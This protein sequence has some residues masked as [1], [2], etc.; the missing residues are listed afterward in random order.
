MREHLT[1][2]VAIGLVLRNNDT[3]SENDL[4]IRR[5]V[6]VGLQFKECITDRYI[7]KTESKWMPLIVTP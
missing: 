2:L 6:S 1:F 7:I 3:D 5:F 4:L